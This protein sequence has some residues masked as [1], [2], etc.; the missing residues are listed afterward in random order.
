MTMTNACSCGCAA[1]TDLTKAE[2][3][4]CG[5]ECCGTEKPKT[6]EQE[7]VELLTLRSQ[8]DRRLTELGA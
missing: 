2:E 6:K 8:I 3:Y 1:V 7:V 5:C 4:G